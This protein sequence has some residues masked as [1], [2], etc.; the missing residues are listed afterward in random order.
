MV[1]RL[2]E[3]GHPRRGRAGGDERRAAPHL[4]RRGARDPRLRRRA[5]ADRPRA[6]DLAAV[7]RRADDRARAQ[8]P[9]ARARA[10]DRHR[11]RLPDRG[12]RARRATTSTRS[13]ASAR[14]SPRRGATCRRSRSE[15]AAQ[16]RRRQRATSARSSRSTRSSSPRARR[17][18]PTALLRYLKPGGRMVLPLAQPGDE[19]GVQRLTVHR[20]DARRHPGADAR[21]GKIRAAACR[22]SRE[23]SRTSAAS[24]AS[25]TSSRFDDRRRAARPRAR[26]RAGAR[27][28]ARRRL[29]DAHACAGRG[30]RAPWRR[31]RRSVA[32]PPPS[33]PPCAPSAPEPDTRPQTYTVK[34][35]DTLYQIALDHGLDYRELA[36]WNNIENLNLI[37]VGQVLRLTAPG[38]PGDVAGPASP[39]RR[40][41][42]AP[43]ASPKRARRRRA[44]AA[45][46]RR[47]SRATP[48]TYKSSAQGVQGAVLRAG[49]ARSSRCASAAPSTVA[50]AAGSGAAAARRARRRRRGRAAAPTR[51]AARRRTTTTT[52]STGCG[53][54]KARSS[55][56]FSETANLKGID[57]AGTAG[58]PVLAS[59]PG[60]VVYA[61]TGLRGYGKLIIIKHNK[62][63]LSAYAHNREI[64]V[65]EGQQVAQGPEDRGDGQ[66]RRRPG[67]AALRD[68]P[69]RQAD[70]SGAV[71]AARMSVSDACARR[72]RRRRRRPRSV[73]AGRAPSDEPTTT[74]RAARHADRAS[75]RSRRRRRGC[76]PTSSP[77]SRS[78]I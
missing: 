64:L 4:R 49:A 73:V 71:P 66:H 47:R 53:R 48:T 54:R 33:P 26:A 58:Q 72:C 75:C 74:R 20:S 52:G 6:D 17:T 51:R 61:G 16:A 36:A 29:R 21:C 63:Y 65:K 28:R 27:R 42:T 55:A 40:C 15:R 60:K 3:R 45:A 22:D 46:P 9:R 59:A 43:V 57:I 8:R 24:I 34:R 76:R 77:T 14:W 31:R 19:R 7:G 62:T 37:R 35:G 67:E 11:L 68:P 69:A 30:P 23:L 38:E 18:C 25:M 56:A 2:R 78:S 13:S 70:G 41:A 12:A 5:A 32:P 1:E 50:T 10:R 44:G 39:P